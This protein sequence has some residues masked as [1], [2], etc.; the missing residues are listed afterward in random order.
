MDSVLICDVT[1]KYLALVVA[2][3]LAACNCVGWLYK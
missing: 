3:W 1:Y 2:M